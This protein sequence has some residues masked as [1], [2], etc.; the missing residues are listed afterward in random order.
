MS[1]KRKPLAKAHALFDKG[2]IEVGG[3]K[4]KI[5]VVYGKIQM[6]FL[7]SWLQNTLLKE[8]VLQEKAGISNL[9]LLP[10]SV[11]SCV[12]LSSR[13]LSVQADARA[14][15]SDST[16]TARVTLVANGL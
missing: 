6:S 1:P 14:A 12:R 4:T 16:L 10:Q 8:N 15:Y 2:L 13:L 5:N 7:A 9:K 3:N 11:R